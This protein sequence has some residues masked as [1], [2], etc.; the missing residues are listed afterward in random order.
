MTEKRTV[1]PNTG[2]SPDREQPAKNQDG[3]D[4]QKPEDILRFY[5]VMCITNSD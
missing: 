5:T 2:R 1:Q 3:Y 4:Y